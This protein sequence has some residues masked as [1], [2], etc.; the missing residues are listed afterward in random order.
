M[1]KIQCQIYCALKYK[2]LC[3]IKYSLNMKTS[4]AK[5]YKKLSYRGSY[6]HTLLLRTK[7]YISNTSK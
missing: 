4:Q 7:M 5:M 6:R 2:Y 1:D 3:Y